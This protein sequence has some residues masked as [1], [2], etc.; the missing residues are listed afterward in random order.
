MKLPEVRPEPS[1]DHG[2]MIQLLTQA[3]YVVRK[4]NV[5]WIFEAKERWSVR[6]DALHI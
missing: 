5:A 4:L 1:R 6:V 2:E 3:G